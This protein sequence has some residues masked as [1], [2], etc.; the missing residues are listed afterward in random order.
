LPEKVGV[1]MACHVRAQNKGNVSFDILSKLAAGPLQLIEKCSGHGGLWGYQT[2][3]YDDAMQ[4]A[5]SVVHDGWSLDVIT[6]ECP[7]AAK[8]LAQKAKEQGKHNVWIV[9]PLVLMA[10]AIDPVFAPPSFQSHS[11]SL[12]REVTND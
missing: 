11:P 5:S 10:S 9:H 7:M 8:H 2:A 3:N 1:H 4:M 6:S 12:P